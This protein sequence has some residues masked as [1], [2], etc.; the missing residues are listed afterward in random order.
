MTDFTY[1]TGQ[2]FR[3]ASLA[4]QKCSFSFLNFYYNYSERNPYCLILTNVGTKV[5]AHTRQ[6]PGELIT[7]S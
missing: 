5:D 4:V 3:A 7:C 6:T 2:R 1:Q